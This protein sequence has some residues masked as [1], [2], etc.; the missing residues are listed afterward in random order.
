MNKK[1]VLIRHCKAEMEGKDQER[2]LDQDGVVQA[3][4]LC[5]K[6]SKILKPN[7]IIFT[8]PF[9]RAVDSLVPL[10]KINQKVEIKKVKFLEEIHIAKNDN[11]TKHQIIEKMWNDPNF[12]VEG[13]ISQIDHY[14]S[15]KSDLESMFENFKK[16]NKDIIIVTHGNLLG[17]I[18]KFL[19]KLDFKFD[20][21]K[22]MSMPDLYLMNFDENNNVINLK[23][24][25]ENIE[26]IFQIK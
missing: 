19:F 8:S 3:N 14:N 21:W 6:L 11:L 9:K 16:E 10:T 20:D 18:I 17:M 23:R 4:S 25:I 12:S 26:K 2:A 7:S 13:S 15:I 1:I 24:D 5:E 22:I